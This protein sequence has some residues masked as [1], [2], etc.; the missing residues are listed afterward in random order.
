MAKT[1]INAHLVTEPGAEIQE[2]V[3]LHID[4]IAGVAGGVAVEAVKTADAAQSVAVPT[5]E[6]FDKVVALA[7]ETKKQLN[8]LLAALK[9]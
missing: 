4:N 1:T 6:E 2:T 9:A 8:A 5:K 7:N 3:L